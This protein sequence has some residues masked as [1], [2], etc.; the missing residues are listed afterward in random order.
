MQNKL[1]ELTDKLYNEGLSKGKQEAE[2][3]LNNAKKEAQQILAAA[4]EEAASILK[5]AQKESEELKSKAEGDIKIASVQTLASVKQ[6]LENAITFKNI[7][8]PVSSLL[9]DASVLK[10]VI[11]TV[12]KAFAERNEGK[13][14]ELLLPEDQKQAVDEWAKSS[15]ASFCKEGVSVAYSREIPNGFKISQKGEGYYL[16]FTD[17]AFEKII[18][19]YI[20]PKTRKL[21]FGE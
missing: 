3:L 17:G 1:Q 13:S 19:E 16:D 15:L 4:K 21:L 18:A 10:S 12:V 11:S 9:S 8:G 20:R 2:A 5:N 6:K 14:L 7:S